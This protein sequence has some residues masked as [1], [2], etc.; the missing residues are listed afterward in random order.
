MAPPNVVVVIADDLGYGDLGCYGCEDIDTPNA[1]ALAD[2]GTRFTDWYSNSPVCTPSRASLMT[3]RYPANAGLREFAG[4]QRDEPGLPA[5]QETFADRFGEAGYDTACFGKWHLGT[6]ASHSPNA[7]GF[8]EF[9]GFKSGCV[10]YYSHIFYWTG[11][12]ADPVHDLWENGDEVWRDGEYLTDLITDR[13]ID[14]VESHEDDDD[15]F[16]LYTAYNAPH[17]PLHAPDEYVDRY[18]H[19]PDDRQ[20]MAAMVA[21]V[22]DGLGEIADALKRTDQY[23][24]TV[25]VFTVDHGTSRETRN[26]LDGSQE[27][28]YGGSTGGFR[29]HKFSLFDGGIHVPTILSYPREMDGGRVCDE[30]S[31]T[32][33]LLPTC[34]DLC[35]VPYDADSVDGESL[36]PTLTEGAPSPHDAVYWEFWDQL[37]VRRGDWKLVLD[38]IE[39]DGDPPDAQLT[40]L[41]EDRSERENR[42]DDRPA[43]ADELAADVREWYERVTDEEAPA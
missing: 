38:P 33:D 13:S 22:D 35:G 34:L 32:M 11:D 16:F 39:E 24:D 23:E 7:H 41:S 1:D 40:D 42:R 31:V 2:D 8:D 30:L 6:Q 19:L 18:D 26:W 17:Y 43:L 4:N 20:R 21:T 27:P 28:Y 15:P 9:F 5:D 3:G 29:G 14:Y 25:F 12:D 37:A 36:V 10:D